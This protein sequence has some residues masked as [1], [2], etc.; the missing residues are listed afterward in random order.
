LSLAFDREG[1]Y[2]FLVFDGVLRR[3]TSHPSRFDSDCVI[4]FESVIRQ[5]ADLRIVISSTWRLAMSIKELR[6]RF[7]PDV[8]ARIVGVTLE[9]L[10]KDKHVQYK[11]IRAY[12]H[13]Q[14]RGESSWIA[15]DDDPE[16]YPRGVPVLLTDPSRGYEAACAV[17]PREFFGSI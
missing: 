8:G 1:M 14:D 3:V 13:C 6:G 4:H 11:E 5:Q 10:D 9:I 7:S 17:R 15:I 16:Q 12:L 2:V